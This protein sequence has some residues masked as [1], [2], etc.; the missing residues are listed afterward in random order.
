MIVAVGSKKG[1]NWPKG[2]IGNVLAA[3]MDQN[4]VFRTA[5]EVG[6]GWTVAEQ[7]ELFNWAGK[8]KAGEDAT[9]VWVKPER[10]MEI[11]WERSNIKEMPSF[12]YEKG[13]YVSVGKKTVGTIVKPRFIRYRT[14]KSVTPKDLRLTQIPDWEKRSVSKRLARRVASRYISLCVASEKGWH[15][16]FSEPP[17]SPVHTH[18]N[19]VEDNIMRICQGRNESYGKTL[20]KRVIDTL[21]SIEGLIPSK[22]FSEFGQWMRKSIQE[23]IVDRSEALE[24]ASVKCEYERDVEDRKERAEKHKQFMKSL[25]DDDEKTAAFFHTNDPSEYAGLDD[26]KMHGVT[27]KTRDGEPWT[28]EIPICESCWMGKHV[29]YGWKHIPDHP[30]KLDPDEDSV[31]RYTCKNVGH[32]DGKRVQCNCTAAWPELLE[33]LEKNKKKTFN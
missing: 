4:G 6:T 26:M 17:H 7:K 31:G 22:D 12:R 10:I 3:F 9:Y 13:K 1:R 20:G 15:K 21:D 30:E 11:Q 23:E 16:F 2:Q 5:G 24:I 8:N 32:L 28:L 33:E 27:P 14:D 19:S 25:K 29:T 18:T